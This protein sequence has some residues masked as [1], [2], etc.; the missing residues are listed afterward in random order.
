VP[1]YISPTIADGIVWAIPKAHSIMVLRNDASVVSDSSALFT[2]DRTAIRGLL[3]VGFGFSYPLAV[4][5]VVVT[6]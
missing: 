6:P 1:L 3:R 5:K 2:S 4:V